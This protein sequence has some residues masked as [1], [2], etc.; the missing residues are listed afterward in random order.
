[1]SK[2]PDTLLL[3][4]PPTELRFRGPFTDVVTSE[5]HLKNPTKDKICFK[6]KTTAPR[7]YC[8]RPN[9]GVLGAEDDITVSVMLQPFDYDPQEKNKHKFM[10]QAMVA[11]QGEFDQEAVWKDKTPGSL[12]ENKLRCVFEMPASVAA[13]TTTPAAQPQERTSAKLSPKPA[14]QTSAA[15]PASATS[16]DTD[17]VK[18]LQQ[19]VASLQQQISKLEKEKICTSCTSKMNMSVTIQKS[20]SSQ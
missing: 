10:V 17:D 8:V 11:P 6:I 5:L 2:A 20:T 3:I 18:R 12:M 19:E 16:R 13:P 15:K 14:H 4:S 7:R 1:M 9:S